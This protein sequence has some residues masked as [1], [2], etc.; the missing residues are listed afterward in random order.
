MIRGYWNSSVLCTRYEHCTDWF[1]LHKQM[2]RS[3]VRRPK[4]LH[5]Q[6]VCLFTSVNSNSQKIVVNMFTLC[7]LWSHKQKWAN[8][9]VVYHRVGEWQNMAPINK[10]KIVFSKN[11]LVK[12]WKFDIYFWDFKANKTF[13]LAVTSQKCFLVF[14]FKT[15]N[16]KQ[17]IPFVDGPHDSTKGRPSRLPRH[18]REASHLSF[19]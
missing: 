7:P 13:I 16:N 8:S 5:Y 18:F 17:K 2:L 9:P 3:V 14:S 15:P 6:P 19:A 12:G 11:L 10:K 1:P 4:Q